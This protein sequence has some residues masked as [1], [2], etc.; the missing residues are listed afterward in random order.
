MALEAAL[1]HELDLA[2]LGGVLGEMWLPI[3]SAPRSTVD[4]FGVVQGVYL[5][6]Y[7]PPEGDMAQYGDDPQVGI[8]VGWWEPKLRGGEGC[9]YD[10]PRV[11]G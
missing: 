1:N 9:W 11:G 5:L 10:G 3:S 4:H 7:V 8:S 2:E 6:V